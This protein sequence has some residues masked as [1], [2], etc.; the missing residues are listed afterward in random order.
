[1]CE[2]SQCVGRQCVGSV[3]SGGKDGDGGGW[4]E[5]ERDN[6]QTKRGE[7]KAEVKSVEKK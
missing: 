1:M 2:C 4:S 6:Y 7:K 3:K 5:R